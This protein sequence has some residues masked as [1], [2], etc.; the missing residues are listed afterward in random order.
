M[1]I[2]DLEANGWEDTLSGMGRPQDLINRDVGILRS[3]RSAPLE[4][5]GVRRLE[6]IRLEQRKSSGEHP[7]ERIPCVA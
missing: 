1:L 4:A 3:L 5:D 7:R 2:F 6:R